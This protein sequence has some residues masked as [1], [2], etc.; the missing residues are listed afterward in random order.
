MHQIQGQSYKIT[1]DLSRFCKSKFGFGYCRSMPLLLAAGALL[2]YHQKNQAIV[3][4]GITLTLAYTSTRALS[5]QALLIKQGRVKLL[6]SFSFLVDTT[7][8]DDPIRRIEYE[9]ALIVVEIDLTWSLGFVSVELGRLP[10]PLSCSY[11]LI[12]PIC[13]SKVLIDAPWF[14][15]ATSIVA[16]ISLIK[17]EFSSFLFANSLTN[18]LRVSS[19]DC[20]LSW[21]S[22]SRSIVCSGLAYVLLHRFSLLLLLLPPSILDDRYAVSNGSGYVVL[23]CWDEYAILERKLDTQL[24]DGSG[25]AVSGYRPE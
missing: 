8:W 21:P 14:L 5:K 6:G 24:S 10:N 13:I 12:C 18:L 3:K 2:Q 25:Y 20:L 23:I 19:I 7:Y 11:L 1:H 16:R 4:R 17:L 9:S 15:M 22:D